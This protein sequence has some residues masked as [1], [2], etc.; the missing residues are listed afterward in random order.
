MADDTASCL[1]Q[2]L[3]ANYYFTHSDVVVLTLIDIETFTIKLEHIYCMV[4]LND[5]CYDFDDFDC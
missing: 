1:D 4:I 2:R 3:N 5:R